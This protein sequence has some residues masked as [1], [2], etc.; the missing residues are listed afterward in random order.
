LQLAAPI[1]SN[2]RTPS[3]CRDAWPPWLPP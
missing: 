3:G 1:A 2:E